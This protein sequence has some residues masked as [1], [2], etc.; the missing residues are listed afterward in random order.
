MSGL[1]LLSLIIPTKN[2]KH[3]LVDTL[4]QIVEQRPS[5]LEVIVHDNSDDL[6]LEKELEALNADFIRYYHTSDPIGVHENFERA[7]RKAN[8]DYLCAIGDDDGLIVSAALDL[9]RQAKAA[10]IDAVVSERI[11][12]SWPGVRHRLWGDSGGRAEHE[13]LYAGLQDHVRDP[14]QS[15]NELF[16]AG[17]LDGLGCLPRVY[18]GYVSRT[19]MNRLRE[20]CGACFPGGSPDM[21]NAA[22]LVGVVNKLL[23]SRTVTHITGHSPGSG[24]GQGAA[25]KHHA[26]LENAVHVLPSSRDNWTPGIPRFW[27]GMT[28]YAQ[29]AI[30]GANAGGSSPGVS[31]NFMALCAACLVYQP[32]VYRQRVREAIILLYGRNWF[33]HAKLYM[34]AG[35]YFVLRLARLV[36]TGFNLLTRRH[37]IGHYA[38]MGE[39]MAALEEQR[40]AQLD[41]NLV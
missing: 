41:Q 9:L 18:H 16:A 19:A 15:L 31:F 39:L 13:N 2:R 21:A 17:S 32:A 1:P 40:Q 28:V 25:G 11:F 34:L 5:S 4:A 12:Y 27:S 8:G 37:V 22:A 6:G 33:L 35:W 24:G 38:T 10:G 20:R 26:K 7:V 3:F 29:A 30:E 36:R 23:V 14:V